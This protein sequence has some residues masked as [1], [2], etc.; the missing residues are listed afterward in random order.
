MFTGIIEELGSVRTLRKLPD[1]ALLTV[2]AAV[3]LEGTKI[4]DSMAVN[5]ICLTVTSLE[6]GE[7]TVDVMSETIT[8]TNLKE[9]KPHDP[10]NLERAL[11]LQ[12]RCGGHFVSGHID[13]IGRIRSTKQEGIAK[14]I[15]IDAPTTITGMIVS[16][17]SIAIDGISLTV[18]DVTPHNF[19]VS[20]I[21]HTLSQTTLAV[22][23]AGGTVNL[24][25][26]MLGKYVA[27]LIQ[28]PKTPGLSAEFL[29]EHG[30]V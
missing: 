16:K 10:V 24:E 30:Y 27:R 2:Q 29:H 11:T 17:G 26:D 28:S 1:S 8:H 25:T 7:F 13:G 23:K 9:L 4:G 3:V 18:V 5:G 20:I 21:P 19:T 15:V 22:K 6:P 12:T 14:I